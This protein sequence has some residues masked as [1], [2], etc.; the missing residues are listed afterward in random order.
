MLHGPVDLALLDE[1]DLL[2]Q[3]EDVGLVEFALQD[4][5]HKL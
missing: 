5:A 4:E 1:F 2:A 3:L